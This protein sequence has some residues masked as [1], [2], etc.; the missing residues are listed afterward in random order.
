MHSL[1]HL[2]NYLVVLAGP[3]SDQEVLEL[4]DGVAGNTADPDGNCLHDSGLA[5]TR[6]RDDFLAWVS[7][8]LF[9]LSLLLALR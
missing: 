2:P 4:K 8:S 3:H 6:L 5:T 9:A 7:L 1:L